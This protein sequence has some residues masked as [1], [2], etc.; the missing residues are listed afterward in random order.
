MPGT[1]QFKVNLKP[2]MLFC[3][4]ST[5]FEIFFVQNGYRQACP[6]TQGQNKSKF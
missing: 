2:A 3:R 5:N 4:V 1:P 6:A